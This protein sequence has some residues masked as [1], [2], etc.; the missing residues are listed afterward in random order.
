MPA[1][2]FENVK[3]SDLA[4]KLDLLDPREAVHREHPAR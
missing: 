3:G 1:I 2:V 4:A